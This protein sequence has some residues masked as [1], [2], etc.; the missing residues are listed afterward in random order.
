MDKEMLRQIAEKG[1][2]EAW[3]LC[4]VEEGWN[5]ASKD[6]GGEAVLEW[7][8]SV[9]SSIVRGDGLEGGEGEWRCWRLKTPL[10]AEVGVVE[11]VIMDIERMHEWNPALTKTQVR[12]GGNF[13]GYRI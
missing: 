10:E 5:K 3:Q 8:K 4:Q 12:F 11:R 2:E 7:R 13:L 1:R 9:P 6:L